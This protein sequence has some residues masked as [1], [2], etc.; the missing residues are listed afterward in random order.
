ML[1]TLSPLVFFVLFLP[2]QRAAHE[3]YTE[4]IS[5]TKITFDM[6]AIPGGTFIMGSPASEPGRAAD[7]GPAHEGR[8]AP[9][10]ME[11]PPTPWDECDAFA[12][13]QAIAAAPR[14]AQPAA[15]PSGA[16]AVT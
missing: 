13:A 9:F 4:T 3:S 12:C 5:G 1:R 15:P 10:W 7:E 14:P 2:T 6:V 16:D 8:S 11:R